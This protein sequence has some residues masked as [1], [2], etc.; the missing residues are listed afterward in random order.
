MNLAIKIP[1]C[2]ENKNSLFLYA[3][4]L[5]AINKLNGFQK[6]ESSI[7]L[8]TNLDYLKEVLK[9]SI[10]HKSTKYDYV[11]VIGI[12]GSNL[13]TKAIYDAMYGYYDL[14]DT[15]RRPKAI[16]VDTVNG[17]YL[18]KIVN[19]LKTG[20]KVFINLVT[21]SGNTVESIANFEM[22]LHKLP[23]LKNNLVVTTSRNNKLWTICES[24]GIDLLSIPNNVGGRFSVF[25]GVGILP[26]SILGVNIKNLL[27]GSKTA[28]KKYLTDLPDNEA[29]KSAIFI[30]SNYK[31]GKNI[32]N[33]FFFKP[34]LESVGKWQ[35]QLLAESLG[36][37]GQGFTPTLSIGTND[38]HSVMQLNLGGPKD[39][40]FSVVSI[41]KDSNKGNLLPNI[42]P[43]EH[44]LSDQIKNRSLDEINNLILQGVKN[45]FIEKKISY[46]HFELKDIS[47][48]AIGEYMQFKMLE[49]MYLGKLLNVNTF[50]QPD[51]EE[52]KLKTRNLM[53]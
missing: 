42:L 35:I 4:Q 45:T 41:K 15:T 51:V 23:E 16:F 6:P 29:I 14:L 36:K 38:L 49:T 26:L 5:K 28:L 7:N 46:S 37:S 43:L 8:A 13:G 47:E 24:Q 21:K 10:R 20:K 52:Y 18:D 40:F 30:N 48:T 53:A 39:K 11:V 44:E 25:S 50:D 12:G 34:E 2:Q 19:L 1:H 9:C 33:H 31:N 22:L 3:K 17:V 32:Y 27:E